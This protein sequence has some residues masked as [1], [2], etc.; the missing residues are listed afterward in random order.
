M[1]KIKLG[2]PVS[3]LL[4]VC[5]F[6]FT[7]CSQQTSSA[8]STAVQST[9]AGETSQT[10]SAAADSSGKTEIFGKVT[11]ID[12]SKITLALG[13]M[14]HGSGQAGGQKR[15]GTSSGE[16]GGA[17]GGKNGAAPQGGQNA[18]S[19]GGG[20]L[21]SGSE[22][23]SSPNSAGKG[24][25]RGM[26][27]SMITLTGET[28]TITVS[29]SSIL[30]KRVFEGR[31]SQQSS[32]GASSRTSSETSAS[33]SDIKTGTILAIEKDSGGTITSIVILSGSG[34]GETGVSSSAQN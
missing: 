29:D 22:T 26:G 32:S 11:A 33:L 3:I 8:S 12:G 15:Q 1:R 6:G 30:K 24:A 16:G 5:T 25:P 14:G 4:T 21:P 18:N 23:P 2:V 34:Q 9:T 31:G 27:G 17:P 28:T 10:A 13:T 19:G 7:A 20:N